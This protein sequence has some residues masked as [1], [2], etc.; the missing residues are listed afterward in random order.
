MLSWAP[1]LLLGPTLMVAGPGAID[2]PGEDRLRALQELV[3][4]FLAGAAPFVASHGA[5]GAVSP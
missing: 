3:G 1:P 5:G 2:E 4:R